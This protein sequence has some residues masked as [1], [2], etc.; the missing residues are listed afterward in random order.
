MRKKNQDTVHKYKQNHLLLKAPT[1]ICYKL[2]ILGRV[3]LQRGHN[4]SVACFNPYIALWEILSGSMMC[5]VKY[6]II[7]NVCILLRPGIKDGFR[8]TTNRPSWRVYF[9]IHSFHKYPNPIIKPFDIKTR[10][11]F[12]SVHP[13]ISMHILH[14]VLCTFAK[15]LTRRI[16]LIIQSFFSWW[17]FPLFSWHQCVIQQ[18]YCHEKL[19]AS[20]S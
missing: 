9:F 14:A 15:V 2:L 11:R 17:S 13:N 3:C 12:N 8:E 1:R 19:D 7:P 5:F 6:F 10:F 16:C 20:H 4:V 18:W